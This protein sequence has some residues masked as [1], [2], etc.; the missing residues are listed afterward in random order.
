MR[1]EACIHAVRDYVPMG[2]QKQLYHIS[3]PEVHP[4]HILQGVPKFGTKAT[5][6][7]IITQIYSTQ[8]ICW[9]LQLSYVPLR[10]RFQIWTSPTI[11]QYREHII[12]YITLSH[13]QATTTP[14]KPDNS[15]CCCILYYNNRLRPPEPGGSCLTMMSNR[16]RLM[17]TKRT[18]PSWAVRSISTA[19]GSASGARLYMHTSA[20]NTSSDVI[21]RI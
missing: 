15:G 4:P 6:R 5:Y 9:V 20:W 10:R 17:K 21:D 13:H 12:R 14:F 16:K 3:R 1:E 8:M 11:P 7:K 18:P 19:D 2:H